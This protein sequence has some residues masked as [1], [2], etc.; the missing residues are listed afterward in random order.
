MLLRHFQPLPPPDPL[1]AILADRPAGLVQQRR[2]PAITVTP[3]LTRQ[4][5]NRGRQRI[6]VDPPHR[7]VAL[8]SSPLLQQPTGPTFADPVLRARLCHRAPAPLGAYKFP[9]ATVLE[10]LLLERQ[11]RYQPLELGVLLLQGLEPLGLVQLQPAILFA[12]ALK[13]LLANAGLPTRLR[14]RPPIRH[15]HLYLAQQR[16]DLFRFESLGRHTSAP[17]LVILSHSRLVQKSPVTSICSLKSSCCQVCGEPAKF[18]CSI[19]ENNSTVYIT[20]DGT[21][22]YC[23]SVNETTN[24]CLMKTHCQVL[25]M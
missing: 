8:G 5:D 20:R 18:A 3:V 25:Q 14:C 13:G 4:R 2:D 10:D 9:S 11:F 1:H 7:R 19:H 22:I 16:H 21:G 24:T 15:H 6:F 17:L 23:V 12:P